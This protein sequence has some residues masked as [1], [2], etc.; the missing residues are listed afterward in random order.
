MNFQWILLSF[1][2]VALLW[3]I[4][5]AITKPMIKN[6]LRLIS[7]PV[8]FLLT[9]LM[10][11]MG[12]F[13]FAVKLLIGLIDLSKFAPGLEL[14]LT[15]GMILGLIGQVLSP[16]LFLF[17]FFAWLLL[18]RL[19]HVNFLVRYINKQREKAAK[20]ALKKRIR[21]E[22]AEALMRAEQS[23]ER[24]A[25][26]LE[27][28]PDAH[29]PY[30]LKNIPDEYEIEEMIEDRVRKEERKLKRRGFFKESSEQKSIS[31]VCGAVS[32]FLIFAIVMMPVFYTMSIVN[33]VKDSVL[34]SDSEDSLV[35]KVV[36][37]ADKHILTPYNDSFIIELYDSMALIDLM[38][39]TVR[40]GGRIVLD[41][42]RVIY[43][44][45]ILKGTVG[46]FAGVATE[47]T[48]AT[49]DAEKLS[50][51]LDV[52]LT[53][54][55][56]VSTAASII[57]TL[58]KD[59]EVPKA[60][61]GN[62]LAGLLPGI[63]DHY[64]NIDEEGITND[65][66]AISDVIVV[67][68]K[69]GII[70]QS[71][72]GEFKPESLL[73][74]KQ[75]IGDLLGS[76]AGLS[77]FEPVIGET[78]KYGVDMLGGVLGVPADNA[79]A[80]DVF[81]TH[82]LEGVNGAESTS[83]DM[84]KVEDFIV[85]CVENG[86]GKVFTYAAVDPE[87][88]EAF[89][90]YFMHWAAVQNAFMHSSED[91]SLAYFTM[92]IG[93]KLYICDRADITNVDSINDMKKITLSVVSD[94]AADEYK[95]KISPLADLVHYLAQK[96]SASI[97]EAGLK[98][99]LGE[100]ALSSSDEVC[101]EV[102]NRLQDRDTFVSKGVTKIN[103][104]NSLNF[105]SED[106]EWTVEE[107]KADAELCVEIIFNLLDMMKSLGAAAPVEEGGEGKGT[108]SIEL[109]LDQFVV[110]GTTMDLMMD[111]SC[112]NKLPP[113]MLEGLV[114][115]EMFSK[116]MTPSIVNQINDKIQNDPNLTYA[117]YMESLVDT[118]KI[119][120]KTLDTNK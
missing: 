64:K 74:D 61:E 97:D 57:P 32:A 37:V 99:L 28:D 41:K 19:V 14:D 109:L 13:Q 17:T 16:V 50:E 23:E 31:V 56:I 67:V 94:P 86:E 75:V 90:E 79:A 4:V 92:N 77:V 60:E 91:R 72:S 107:R 35:Y 103:L 6:V 120:L 81:M 3:G 36:D 8:A 11:I 2:A 98:T 25:K 5:Q 1:F 10:Q 38:N 48:S 89:L 87:G 63:V 93:D 85:N 9:F 100:Y 42:D 119:A 30:E 71:V 12:V 54:P 118:F 24:R 101:V 96:S 52:I 108:E 113:L 39:Y 34:N 80:Y 69:Q 70:I 59:V 47:L 114:K 102:A 7:V 95:N 27:K 68:A 58:L 116:F 40:A 73:E 22:K 33:T 43:A 117:D 15:S 88:S 84:A 78:L 29:L 45:D 82:L 65:L 18:L 104:V 83:F 111:T 53:N 55:V 51:H 46:S 106:D 105:G 26:I 49:P 20:R 21:E 62:V 76:M 112:M 115:H 44:D 110:L 66:L